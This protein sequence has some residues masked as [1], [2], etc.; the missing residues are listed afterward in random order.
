MNVVV[1]ALALALGQGQGQEQTGEAPPPTAAPSAPAL[2][3]QPEKPQHPPL[4]LEDALAR[5]ATENLDLHAAQARLQ[6]A[7][8]ISRQV[9]SNQLPQITAG[10]R[11]TRNER[12]VSL[13]LSETQT[14]TLVALD[15]LNAQ[16]DAS[17]VLFAPGLWLA[18]RNAYRTENVAAANVEAARRDILFVVAQAYYAVAAFKQALEVAERLLE[19]AQRQERD[20]RVRFQAGTIPKVGLLR[21][22][23][24]RARAEQDVR[25][26]VNQYDSA[27]VAL[28]T[29]LNRDTAFDVVDPPEPQ[30]G[31]TVEE[32][33]RRAVQERPELRAAGLNVDIARNQRKQLAADYLPI[34]AAFGQYSWANSA[35]FTGQSEAWVAGLTATWNI[36][37]GGLREARR[38]EAGARIT[39]VEA[40]R[41]SSVN[42]VRAE[43]R[44]AWLDYESARANAAKAREQRGLAAENLRLIDV[45]Y[46]AGAA[47]AVEQADATAQLRTAE[48]SVATEELQ[49][50]LA[51]LRVQR[52]AGEFQPVKRK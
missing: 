38:S 47:T 23:I 40:T 19:I 21:A 16:V 8:T 36:F 45:S 9:W 10:A 27:K 35:G 3:A 12:E 14:V 18:I 28:A 48:I 13:P 41:A 50:Q 22:E 33:E 2:E 11:Y 5:A 32:L 43:V 44:Q 26:A 17:Q 6:Q 15:Q 24:D 1:I 49:A 29:L 30:L 31:G 7:N 42:N 25:R 34:V 46:R 51:A 37:D 52:A 39:E 4:T 20:T